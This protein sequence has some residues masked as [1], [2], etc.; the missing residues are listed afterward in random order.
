MPGW[1]EGDVPTG[2]PGNEP[3]TITLPC[4]AGDGTSSD[5]TVS[6]G[7]PAEPH[8]SWRVGTCHDVQSERVA[9][10]LGGSRVTCLDI[11]DFAVPAIQA[12]WNSLGRNA[13]AGIQP[14]P[15]RARRAANWGIAEP[16]PGCECESH[17]WEHPEAAASHLR[18]LSHW[19]RLHGAEPEQTAR[20]LEELKLVTGHDQ[21]I[22][23]SPEVQLGNQLE[24]PS[25]LFELWKAGVHPD[26]VQQVHSTLGLSDPL[27]AAAYLQIVRQAID[28]DWLRQFTAGGPQAVAWAATS[29]TKWDVIRPA[30]RLEWYRAGVN[31]KLI[32][33]LREAPYCVD[34]VRTLA[35]ATDV[36]LNA[37]CRVI[38]DWLAAGCSPSIDDLV[39][40]CRLVPQGRQAPTAAAITAVRRRTSD[41]CD[42]MTD[43]AVGLILVAAGTPTSAAAL[44]NRGIST[45][46]DLVSSQSTKREH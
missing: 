1:E 19:C 27:S 31:F 30:D 8:G 20:V 43:T 39:A 17:G 6:V 5:H 33:A 40:V 18:L 46:H 13:L 7:P 37:A 34:D 28:L 23:W 24:E 32:T 21:W 25:T 10:A 26:V 2:F 15:G 16:A 11:I 36:S 9:V 12:Y 3:A 41:R 45:M 42:D 22:P 38:V 14:R 29:H 44:I 35:G 4:S